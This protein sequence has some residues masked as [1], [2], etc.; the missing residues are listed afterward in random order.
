MVDALQ[1]ADDRFHCPV[2][3]YPARD[4]RYTLIV[5]PALGVSARSYGML[6]QVLVGAGY[7]VLVADWPGQGESRPRPNWRFNYG[8]RQLVEE[9]LP[10][11]LSLAGRHFSGT[12]LVLLGH[13]LGGHIATLYAAANP[14]SPVRVVGVACGNIHYRHWSGLGRL[15]TPSVAILCN[16][17]AGSLG[18]LPGK[19]IGFGGHEARRLMRDWG[20]VAFSGNYRHLDLPLAPAT[21]NRVSSLFIQI[22]NDNF[23]PPASTRGLAELIQAEPQIAQLPSPRPPHENPH[24]AWLRAPQGV[25]ACVKEWLGPLPA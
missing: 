4:A 20:R 21:S 9:F 23:A 19:R 12:Q 16:L 18:H 7:N 2:T 10:K 1:F 6:A 17:L 22:E 3:L 13:S 15:L 8:Y 24:S 5:L 25:V 11:L 14:A